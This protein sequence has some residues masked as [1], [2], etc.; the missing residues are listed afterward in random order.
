[1]HAFSAPRT[2]HTETSMTGTQ[3]EVHLH[4]CLGL[5]LCLGPRRDAA[6][7]A[8]CYAASSLQSTRA[9]AD[10]GEYNK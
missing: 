5:Q 7:A 10:Q 8:A 1:M 4:A 3:E 9:L 2:V 6:A